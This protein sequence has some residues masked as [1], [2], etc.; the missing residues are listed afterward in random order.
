MA[1]KEVLVVVDGDEKTGRPDPE[2]LPILHSPKGKMI[3]V[4]VDQSA[5]S[6]NVVEFAAN[7]IAR[8]EDTVCLVTVVPFEP[9]P[10]R[11]GH[12]SQKVKNEIKDFNQKARKEITEKTQSFLQ[13]LA[14]RIKDINAAIHDNCEFR[15]F[16]SRHDRPLKKLLVTK[17]EKYKPS[18]VILGCR[19][20]GK[21]GRTFL[22]SVSDFVV[23]NSTVPVA[24]VK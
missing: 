3:F 5:F 22:G 8:P 18:L 14:L 16:Y 7:H 10:Y 15:V 23:H 6:T 1:A 13:E 24:I 9:V 19:G 2:P 20:L 11:T 4:C 17:I 12:L 21:V